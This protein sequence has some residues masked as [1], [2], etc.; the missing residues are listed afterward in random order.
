MICQCCTHSVVFPVSHEPIFVCRHYFLQYHMALSLYTRITLSSILWHYVYAQNLLSPVS[1]G[2]I[3]ILRTEALIFF[4][5]VKP[6]VFTN[7]CHMI[8]GRIF[9]RNIRFSIENYISLLYRIYQR[10]VLFEKICWT[11]NF[12]WRKFGSLLIALDLWTTWTL[13]FQL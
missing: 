5:K 9:V 11:W 6:S 10:T 4:Q 8:P 12:Q 3:L 7:S 1:Y 13:L 2:T